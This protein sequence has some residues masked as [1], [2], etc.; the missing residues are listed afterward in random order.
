MT[1]SDCYSP[2]QLRNVALFADFYGPAGWR[3]G[4]HVSFPALP[5]Q[6]RKI[7]F[8]RGHGRDFSARDRLVLDLLRPH[9]WEIYDETQRRRTKVPRL[10]DRD[11][12]VLELVQHGYGNIEIARHLCISVSTVRKHLEHV[13]ER[14]GARTRTAAVALMLPRR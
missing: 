2:G 9:L 7:S 12:E 10:T 14:T 13:F 1:W 5:G 4:M 8:W 11:W 3:S 6:L